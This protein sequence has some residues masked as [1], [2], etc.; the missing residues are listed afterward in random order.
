M[1]HPLEGMLHVDYRGV[2]R[3]YALLGD[4]FGLQYAHELEEFSY[5]LE[6][7]PL[8]ILSLLS[9]PPNLVAADLDARR[10]L[11]KAETMRVSPFGITYMVNNLVD[12][13]LG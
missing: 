4:L 13:Y 7:I 5:G 2:D 1:S 6:P 9:L 12:Y 8:D 11:A 3:N 10:F